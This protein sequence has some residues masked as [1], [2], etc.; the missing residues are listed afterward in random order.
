MKD[1]SI[2]AFDTATSTGWAHCFMKSPDSD[3]SFESGV[4]DFS[5]RTKPTKTIDAEPKG[6]RFSMAVEM[7]REIIRST[8]PDFILYEMVIGGR[9]AGG[10]TSLI[11]KGLEAILLAASYQEARFAPVLDV[12]A[13]TIKKWAT[14]NGTLSTVGKIEMIA[15]AK[16][17]FKSHEFTPKRP[18][19]NT[20]W[21]VSDDEVDAM[22]LA[23]FG[24]AIYLNH[25]ERMVPV[26]SL[27][28]IEN[29]DRNK[30]LNRICYTKWSSKK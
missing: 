30:I 18:T 3:P 21:D 16:R 6:K 23:D 15:A 8:S 19:K 14:G 7:M 13:G 24:R 29:K 25:L 5:I 11:Q 4:F 22:W 20:P 17:E 10:N 2:L 1:I 26:N 12:A 27:I 28:S 9:N